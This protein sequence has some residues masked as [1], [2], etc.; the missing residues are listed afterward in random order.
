MQALELPGAT[1]A[2]EPGV[3][4]EQQ[5]CD[6]LRGHRGCCRCCWSSRSHWCKRCSWSDRASWCSRCSWATGARRRS[7]GATGAATGS[8]GAATGA[9]VQLGAGHGWGGRRCRGCW[10]E[11]ATGAATREQQQCWGQRCCWCS[12]RSNWCWK[13]LHTWRLRHH[14]IVNEWWRCSVPMQQR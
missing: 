11:A 3:L 1:G 7:P 10:A 13:K 5:G 8:A 9:T 12:R 6:W 2:L 4:L 14:E